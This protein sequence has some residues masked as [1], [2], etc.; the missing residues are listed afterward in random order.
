[1][2]TYGGTMMALV[3][4]RFFNILLPV[5]LIA[6]S[7][8]AGAFTIGGAAL[9]AE[10]Q[11]QA[12]RRNAEFVAG[13]RS[14]VDASH[15]ELSRQIRTGVRV[16]E[17]DLYGRLAAGAEHHV[18]LLSAEATA[19]RRAAEA[20]GRADQTVVDIESDLASIHAL[21]NRALRIAR[22]ATSPADQAA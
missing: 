15:M 11:R 22:L 8:A 17:Q 14:V 13:L 21:R 6:L 16:L 9:A 7:A 2:P 5:W 10:R 12:G 18:R 1:M 3:L 19:A 4:P 20:L